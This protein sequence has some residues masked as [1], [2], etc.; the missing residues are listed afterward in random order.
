MSIEMN[1]RSVLRT[2]VGVAGAASMAPLLSA[3]G[4]GSAVKSGANTKKG[5]TSAVPAYT[6]NTSV[7]PDIPS[8]SFANGAVTDP[9]F[10]TYPANPVATVTGKP[11][12]GGSYT[13]VTPLWGAVPQAGNSFYTAV[14]A[15]LGASLTMHPADGNTFNT[16]IT[17]L[18]AAKKL[19]D[20]VQLPTWW[21]QTFNTGELAATQLAD[22]TPYLA[23]DKVKDYPNLAAIPTGAWKCGVWD[24]KLYGIPSF[25]SGTSF[26]G[27]T[28]YRQD[29]FEAKGIS[30]SE[31][32]S[33]ADLMA[34]GKELTSAS[35]GVWAFDD[36][37]TYLQPAF[38]IA[39]K[40]WIKDGKLA[41]KY[42]QPEF[43]EA[44]DWHYQLAKS[45]SVH[46]DALAGKNS[47]AK[48]RF[49]AGKVLIEG[50]GTGAWNLADDQAGKAASKAYRRGAFPLFAADGKSTP[51]IYLGTSTSFV[52]YLNAKLSPAQIKEC[53][54]IANYLAAPWGSA[55]YTLINYGVE[56][57]DYTMV[58][59]V[60]TFT[61]EGQKS[62]QQQTFPFLATCQEVISNPGADQLTKD[63]TAWNTA[64]AKYAYKSVFWNMNITVPARYSTADAAQAVEDTVKDVYHGIKPVSAFQEA[65]ST[66]KKN[67]GTTLVEWY[68]TN[69]MDKYGTDQ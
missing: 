66:W 38:G 62:V 25:S 3:C 32:T 63:Y 65:V 50:D 17:T 14:N 12:S 30:A 56:G 22:L 16:A 31:V 35:A 61:S 9:G 27:M 41:H 42:D 19:P 20:W 44:L 10:L 33:A 53:L 57:T 58:G 36:V 59:G 45:G 1:R 21:N 18:T 6:A 37:W 2:A 11:G 39:N 47:D 24:D 55:E 48:A 15:A 34:L 5:V 13:A 60:P 43:L 46:P 29:V 69:V 23:G 54:A 26:A 4:S 51:S 68:Q 64:T 7:K 28:Y 40:F 67:G 49:Y 8:V 52:S